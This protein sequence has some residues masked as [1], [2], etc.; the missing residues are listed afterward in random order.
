LTP[1]NTMIIHT[2]KTFLDNISNTITYICWRVLN[3]F[4]Q[5]KHPWYTHDPLQ[6]LNCIEQWSLWE[7]HNK[8]QMLATEIDRL[9]LLI[10]AN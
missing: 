7:T 4:F 1:K 8:P 9:I 3:N 5:N 2:V 6:Y 10:L